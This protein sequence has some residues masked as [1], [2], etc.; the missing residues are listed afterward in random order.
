MYLKILAKGKASQKIALLFCAILLLPFGG[1]GYGEVDGGCEVG[2]RSLGIWGLIASQSECR[3]PGL[4]A[5]DS[6]WPTGTTPNVLVYTISGNHKTAAHICTSPPSSGGG[7]CIYGY[8]EAYAAAFCAM[9][10]ARTDGRTDGWS[11]E[12]LAISINV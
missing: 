5:E 6:P 4:P 3:T 12:W 10:Q 7:E 1:T 8:T 2:K 11:Y 9:W